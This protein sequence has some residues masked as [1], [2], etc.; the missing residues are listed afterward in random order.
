MSLILTVRDLW[1]KSCELQVIKYSLEG[2]LITGT[3][4]WG[5]NSRLKRWPY[6]WS[7]T[8]N[9]S[10]PP[11][12]KVRVALILPIKKRIMGVELSISWNRIILGCSTLNRNDVKK[13]SCKFS[14]PFKRYKIS[15]TILMWS[16][17]SLMERN[18]RVPHIH[19]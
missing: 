15:A 12:N 1:N 14:L 8:K 7:W 4:I 5:Q 16:N 11:N 9:I 13:I 17:T 3:K 6:S 19:S 2:L 10:V 18:K